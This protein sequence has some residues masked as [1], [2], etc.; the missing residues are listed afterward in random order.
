[1]AGIETMTG[2]GVLTEELTRSM[3]RPGRKTLTL[4]DKALSY[5]TPFE[6]AKASVGSSFER[7]ELLELLDRHRMVLSPYVDVDRVEVNLRALC[8]K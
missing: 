1:M 2:I 5:L 3:R 7:R 6:S 4:I 8:V